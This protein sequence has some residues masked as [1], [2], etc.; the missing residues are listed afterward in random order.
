MF[1]TD[2]L[3]KALSEVT[4]FHKKSSFCPNKNLL[5]YRLSKMSS[6]YRGNV[7][8]R[9]VRDYYKSI[10]KRVVH[11]G[12]SAS[13]DML[14]NG[15]R[16]EVKSAL[17]KERIVNGKAKY[18]YSFKHIRPSNFHK[19]IMIFISPEGFEIRSMDS[20]TVAKYLGCKYTHK[21]LNMGKRIIG[22][23]LAA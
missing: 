15:R 2:H 23:R 19:L 12:G 1:T 14:V 22:S 21:T 5:T 16:I 4:G 17:S 11:I 10:G 8:E 20:R 18:S 7:L 9:M 3:D 6:Q 13:F